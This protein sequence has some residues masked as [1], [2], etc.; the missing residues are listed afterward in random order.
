MDYKKF[1]ETKILKTDNVGFDI[2][3]SDLNNKLFDFQKAVVRWSLK[4]GKSA[5]FSDCG[6]GKTFMQLEWAKQVNKK[7]NKNILILAPLAV[8]IQ[9]KEE[10]KKIG[11]EVNIINNDEDIKN[12]IN[13]TNYEKLHKFDLSKFIGIEL[14][15]SYYKQAIKNLE[16]AEKLKKQITLL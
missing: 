14:K 5:I 10:G 9:T 7:T 3:N 1:L 2:D 13:I 11:I 4:K 6:T 16:I 8:S 15:E 12:G